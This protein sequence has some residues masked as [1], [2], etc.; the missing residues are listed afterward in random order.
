[1]KLWLVWVESLK[2]VNRFHPP[3]DKPDEKDLYWRGG[4]RGDGAPLMYSSSVLEI[5]L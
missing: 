5:N 2:C 1:M 3:S 4:R